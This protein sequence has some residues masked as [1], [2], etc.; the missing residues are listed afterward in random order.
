VFAGKSSLAQGLRDGFAL[1][2]PTL[3]IGMSFGVLAEPVVGAVAAGAMSLLVFAGTAQFAAVSTLALGGGAPA[4]VTA[5]LLM[6]MR[7]L[8]MGV[9]AAPAWRGGPLR[10]AVEGQAVIDTS[11]AL[12]NRGDGTFD[13][14]RMIGATIPQY[15]AWSAGTVAGVVAG[16]AL[17]DPQAL[18]L[19]AVFPAF[20]LTL[21]AGEVRD[22]AALTSAL[23]GAAIALCLIPVAPPG[24]PVLAAAAAALLG[25]R[26]RAR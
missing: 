21:L 17:G 7:F 13:R 19:D 4:A 16:A 18:G 5:G 14:A 22:R 20:Y 15:F 12:S 9:A 2:L 23:L 25:L 11:W 8:A 1:V 24:I 3:V 26:R 10:R 6:N